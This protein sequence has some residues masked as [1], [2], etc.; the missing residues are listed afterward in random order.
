MRVDDHGPF[1]VGVTR[2]IRRR[3][4]ALVF[5]PIGLEALERPGIEWRFLADDARELTPEL[6]GDLDG[7]CHFS[8]AVTAAS[9]DGVE[10]LAIVARHGV[11]LDSVDLDACTARG[12][13]VTVTPEAVT[14][15]MA[16]AAVV[17]VLALAHRL[18]DRDRA[19]RAGEWGE[20]RF[21][22][23]GLGLTGR[24][25][26]VI[27]FGRIGREVVR[28]LAPWEMRVLVATR[29]PVPAEGIGV[30]PV[31]LDVLL[32]EADV[33]VVASPLTPETR[34]LLDARRLGLMKPTAFLV[35]VA[36]GPIVDQGALVDALREGRLAGAGLDV[37]E[38][39]PI[40]VA[41]ELLALPNV[42]GAPHSLG[43]T[44]ELVRGCVESVCNALLTVAAGDVPGDVAN[45]A[46][47]ESPRFR[48]KLHRF[49][50]RARAE[51][52]RGRQPRACCDLFAAVDRRGGSRSAFV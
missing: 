37:F 19:L 12:I 50:E 7:L 45:P 29:S 6:L 42:V 49:A 31:V 36:R 47:L 3:D 35:N 14:R 2:D 48:E 30:E 26:G 25:L 5:A 1:R 20:G 16:S 43:Y 4:G 22:P 33:V 40:P 9:L 27:G 21:V 39:E 41:D 15:P 28:L 24:T 23:I 13:A 11:G 52:G 46:V 38:R 18:A 44:D 8:P 32:A 51:A 17:L 34:H 10:R